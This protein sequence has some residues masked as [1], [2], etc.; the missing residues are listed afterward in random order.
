MHR[1]KKWRKHGAKRFTQKPMKLSLQCI[2]ERGVNKLPEFG[3]A[4]FL[5]GKAREGSLA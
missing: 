4:I 2:K 3:E 5:S 1:A